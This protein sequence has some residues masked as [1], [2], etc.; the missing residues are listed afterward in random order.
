LTERRSRA[1]RRT[2]TG[3]RAST[4]STK[5]RALGRELGLRGVS[6]FDASGIF[7]DHKE[8]VY[9]DACHFA[10]HGNE[11]LADAVGAELLR[12]LPK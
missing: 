12:V 8:D 10:E 7:L 1:G 11:I 6:F 4:A 5:F 2:R 9:F 3:W